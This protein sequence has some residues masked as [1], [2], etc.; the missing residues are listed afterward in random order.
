MTYQGRLTE[1]DGTSLTG[2]HTI[3]FRL[4]DAETSGT[5]L[6]EEEHHVTM[7]PQ[8]NGIFSLVLGSLTSFE[9]LNFNRPFWLTIDVDGEGEMTPRQRLTAV[10]YAINADTLDGADST[11]FLRADVDTVAKGQLKL[12][13]QGIGLLIQPSADPIADTKLLDVRNAAGLS[14]FSVDLEGDVS[15]AGD[16]SVTGLISGS[17]ATTGTTSSSWTIG[18]GTDAATNAVSLLFGQST[19]QSSIRF[20]GDSTGDFAFSNPIRLSQQS[21]L[22]LEGATAGGAYV[23]LKAPSSPT[24]YTL[25]FPATVGTT[26]QVLATDAFGNLSWVN[27]TNSGGTITG[28]TAGAGLTGGGSSGSVTLD[29]GS[30]PG[31]QVNADDV[32][33]KLASGAGLAVDTAGLSLL[34]TCTDSQLLKWNATTTAWACAS[35]LDTNAG[36]TITGVTAGNGLTGG[37]TTGA[38]T[39]DVGAGTG[40]VVAAD[41]VSVDVGTTANKIVQLDATGAL[42]AVSGAN[43]TT[44]NAAALTSGTVADGRLSANVSLLGPSIESAEITDGTI[45]AVDTAATFLVAGSGVTLTK[46]ASS[47]QLSATGSGG[48]IT[49]VTAGTGLTGGGSSGSVTVSLATP[50]SVANGGTGA[51]S[52][53][54][55]RSALGAAAAGANSDITALSGLTTALSVTQGGTGATTAGSAR[56]ALSAAASGANSDITSLS[57]LTT[58]LSVAQG[59]TGATT[60]TA[61]TFLTG[62]GTSAVTATSIGPG[63]QVTSSQLNVKCLP[64]GGASES[65]HNST[66]QMAAFGGSDDNDRLDR[67]WPV[68]V[69]ASITS[70]ST[71]VKTAPGSGKSW[72]VTLRKNAA[73]T[74]LSCVI[75]GSSTSCSASGSVTFTAGDRLGVQFVEGGSASGTQGSGWSACFVPN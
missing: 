54:A 62:Q 3:K 24:T 11:Q 67:V 41:T 28:V 53:D 12:I 22:R 45:T 72:T 59:G 14:K 31:I 32:T 6:W 10:G 44:L 55:A 23:A 34:R 37:G 25:T 42:P 39:L 71:F 4:Y 33:L 7:T 18:S 38:V 8:D 30:G 46:G 61:G 66:F 13:S 40:L 75:S 68:P 2:E 47:W 64:I 56:T 52:A 20:K 5:K 73:D 27:D 48:T 57:G 51:T 17:I 9:T 70:L 26:G 58:S 35:D 60:F 19:G 49:G 15:V 50:V 29:L 65:S 63:L 16:L 74:S 43:L 21:T 36:G 69:S 1:R